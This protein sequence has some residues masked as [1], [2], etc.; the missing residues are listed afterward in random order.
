VLRL[1]RHGA[2]PSIPHVYK[3]YLEHYLW[4]ENT[5]NESIVNLREMGNDLS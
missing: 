3:F 1:R 5:E 4:I 2:I